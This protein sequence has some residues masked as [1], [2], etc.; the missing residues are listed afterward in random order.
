MKRLGTIL[1]TA[2]VA[3]LPFA[4]A[5]AE[6]NILLNGQKQYYTVQLRSDKQAI[7]YARVVFENASSE[8]DLSTYEFSLP[9][10]VSINNLSAQQILAKSSTTTCKTYE[11]LEQWQTRTNITSNSTYDTTK[12]CVVTNTASYVEDY[13]YDK[14]ISGSTDYYYYSYYQQRDSKFEY[15]DLKQSNTNG[16]YTVTLSEAV[17]P[18]KQGSILLTFTTRD[19][20]S[21]GTFGRYAYDVRTLLAKQMIDKTTVAVNFDDDMFTREATQQRAYNTTSSSADA[22]SETTSAG[23]TYQ[24]KS[25][26][27]LIGSIGRG[28]LYVKTQSSLLPG[29]MLSVT[30]IFATNSTALFTNEILFSLL[31]LVLLALGIGLYRIWRKGHPSRTHTRKEGSQDAQRTVQA[32]TTG[33]PVRTASLT[34]PWRLIVLTSCVS[35]IGT[36]FLVFALGS[37]LSD[38]G[39]N[40]DVNG[41]LTV[42]GIIAVGLFSGVIAPLLYAL[43]FGVEDAFRWALVHV[44][45]ITM[46]LFALGAFLNA[47]NSTNDAPSSYYNDTLN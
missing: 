8:T 29:D 18:K 10:G 23:S 26:D 47:T 15:T 30:G 32:A 45:F 9:S 39:S 16:I 4:P 6:S 25:M 7:V 44:A 14:N 27:S 24:S 42:F 12:K 11:T 17:K 40:G 13:D 38:A 5:K 34:T 43:R 21:G 31:L 3:L 41:M 19:F 1:L 35:I 2:L 20:I 37:I 28:G 36:L 33:S 22:I 46:L